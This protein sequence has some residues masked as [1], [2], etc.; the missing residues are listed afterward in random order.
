MR[1]NYAN[2]PVLSI[3]FTRSTNIMGS[4][5]RTFSGASS[6]DHTA[7]NHAFIVTEDHGQLFATE[8][9]LSGLQERS[10]EE[11]TKSSNRIVSLYIWKGFNDE[12]TREN[13][14]EHLAEIRR[15]SGEESKYDFKGLFTF[16]PI[17]NK[18]VKADPKKQ[19]CSENCA[20][21]LKKYGAEFI[22]DTKL[23]PVDLENIMKKIENNCV[24][25]TDYY[26]K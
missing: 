21:I 10:L 24:P 4:L 9:T 12:V 15:R 8:E 5:I 22:K 17:I 11:Y 14:Q 16:V 13:V 3:G 2:I 18:F 23:S 25:V 6:K 1:I 26:I 19:W 20:S 7:P